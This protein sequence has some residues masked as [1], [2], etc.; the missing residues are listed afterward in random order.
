MFFIVLCAALSFV[1]LPVIDTAHIRFE[2]RSVQQSH[3]FTFRSGE[4]TPANNVL[5]SQSPPV[6]KPAC[7]VSIAQDPPR[8]RMIAF[9]GTPF[10]RGA[11][12]PL[13]GTAP[14][15]RVIRQLTISPRIV[16]GQFASWNLQKYMVILY[17]LGG[18][19]CSGTLISPKWVM[20]AAHCRITKDHVVSLGKSQ[21]FKDRSVYGIRRVFSHPSF[22]PSPGVKQ[23]E[24]DIAVVEIDRGPLRKS[25]F[26]R[27]NDDAEFPTDRSF[28][29]TIGY[30]Q[31]SFENKFA[32]PKLYGLRQVDLPVM[33]HSKC[34]A[35]YDLLS[36]PQT[37]TDRS[38]ICAGYTGRKCDT[39]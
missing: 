31:I 6:R 10:Q 23:Y 37:I 15:Q 20:T 12:N 3:P 30:G 19:I 18:S 7:P 32:D 1:L 16:G 35:R 4:E 29:R 28:V 27:I 21:A 9:P 2:G 25:Q 17:G 5:R 36:V 24:Y 26:M 14:F 11:R 38:Q 34:Q 39:W 8:N 33:P 13:T 22:E